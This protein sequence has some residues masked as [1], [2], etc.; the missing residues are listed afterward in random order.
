M[1]SSYEQQD[2][3]SKTGGDDKPFTSKIS[4]TNRIIVSLIFLIGF[5][6]LNYVKFQS[7]SSQYMKTTVAVMSD[8]NF[9]T[10]AQNS[11]IVQNQANLKFD[12]GHSDNI[13][14]HNDEIK[15]STQAEREGGANHLRP[16]DPTLQTKLEPETIASTDEMSQHTDDIL[17]QSSLQRLLPMPLPLQYKEQYPVEYDDDDP[18]FANSW[19]C[20][21]DGSFCSEHPDIPSPRTQ[22][23]VEKLNGYKDW[24]KYHYNLIE[25]AKKFDEKLLQYYQGLQEQQSNSTIKRPIVILGDSIVESWNGTWY[26]NKQSVYRTLPKNLRRIS[27][28]REP[29]I[30]DPDLVLNLGVCGDHTQHLLYRIQ[31]FNDDGNNHNVTDI[32]TTT[33]A[34]AA[35]TASSANVDVEATMTS[36]SAYR[37]KYQD[38]QPVVANDPNAIFIVLI[39]TNNISHKEQPQNTARGILSIVKYLIGNTRGH[40]VVLKILPRDHDKNKNRAKVNTILQTQIQPLLQQPKQISSSVAALAHVTTDEGNKIDSQR[41]V[42]QLDCGSV[43]ERVTT[44]NATNDV[45]KHGNST[46]LETTELHLQYL[47]DGLHPNVDGHQLL[48][49]C[50]FQ[51]ITKQLASLP[52]VLY[53]Y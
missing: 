19:M 6:L 48:M 42:G 39:G 35:A 43:F 11:T 8:R 34:A 2:S 24:W 25:E 45:I 20:N 9:Q 46:K 1:S 29:N 36:E 31:S 53:S 26:G 51:Y 47:S 33:A 3:S 49:R 44:L 21:A 28:T 38:L 17:S 18:I 50:V 41:L 40:L 27:S 10:N 16:N 12:H 22:Y 7:I 37:P 14:G 52:P 13:P 30:F 23:T 5:I 15:T 32:T 4:R